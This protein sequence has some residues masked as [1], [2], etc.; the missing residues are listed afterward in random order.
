MNVRRNI[1]TEEHSQT[2][3]HAHRN[4]PG[5]NAYIDRGDRACT[6]FSTRLVANAAALTLVSHGHKAIF[7]F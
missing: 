3:R 4:A 2:D 7:K 1:F 5:Q 6:K